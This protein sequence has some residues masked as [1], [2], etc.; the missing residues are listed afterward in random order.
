M[1]FFPKFDISF[2]NMACPCFNDCVVDFIPKLLWCV[3]N[4]CKAAPVNLTEIYKP[5]V[6]CMFIIYM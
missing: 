1:I 2:N 6:H 4:I 3:H 5:F